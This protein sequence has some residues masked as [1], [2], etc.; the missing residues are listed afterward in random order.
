MN[1]SRSVHF[2]VILAMAVTA[3]FAIPAFAAPPAGTGSVRLSGD[4]FPDFTF[5]IPIGNIAVINSDEIVNGTAIAIYIGI[6]YQWA[7]AFAAVL[8]VL[9]FTYAGVLWLIAGGDSGKVTESKKIMGNAIIGLLLALGSYV[10][11]NAINPNLVHFQPLKVP[12]VKTISLNLTPAS[13]TSGG[14]TATYDVG[15]FTALGFPAPNTEDDP[16]KKIPLKGEVLNRWQTLQP[17]AM[18]AAQATGTDV[19]FIGMW[20]LYEN[21]FDTFMDNCQDTDTNQNTPCSAWG[22]GWQVGLGVHPGNMLWAY[23]GGFTAMYGDASDATVQK[24][25]QSVLD[26]ARAAGKPITIVSNPFPAASLATTIQSAKNGDQQARL[27]IA[28]LTKDPA[29]GLYLVGAHFGSRDLGG[30]GADLARVMDMWDK[31]EKDGYYHPQRISNY[32]KAVY[33][34]K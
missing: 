19:G 18:K 3:L 10:F 8:A 11:L 7:V 27:L 33:D 30:R 28:T 5:Q 34:A 17:L 16:G 6:I 23:D 21:G 4:T 2:I 15:H 22:D 25:G 31:K 9:A 13:I 1:I 12:A 24:V 29:L 20:P 14:I 32:I 26:A